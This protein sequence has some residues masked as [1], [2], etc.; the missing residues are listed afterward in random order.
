MDTPDTAPAL[1][2][3]SVREFRQAVASAA[4]EE[5]EVTPVD[6]GFDV[7]Y[8]EKLTQRGILIRIES[9]FRGVVQ[10][11]PTTR[12]FTLADTGIVDHRT[13]AGLRRTTTSFQGRRYASRTVKAYGEREDG[14]IGPVSTQVQNTRVIHAAVRE[15]A[16]ALGWTEEQPSSA[17]VGKR[18][19][20]IIGGGLA[21]AGIAIAVLAIAG[22]F[23]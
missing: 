2:D 8:R 7:V 19:A 16:A 23:P 13:L 1:E 11:D 9:T 3:G 17:K 18:V 15:P 6:G 10:C 4:P 12:T 22:V 14:T 21:V 20:W 5:L